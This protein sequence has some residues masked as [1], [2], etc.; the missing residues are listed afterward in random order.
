MLNKYVQTKYISKSRGKY[1]L[2]I[3]CR[4][5]FYHHNFLISV[6]CSKKGLQSDME[7]EFNETSLHRILI[8]V[9]D[10]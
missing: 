2:L 9:E 4:A 6:K 5:T 7:V 8:Y 3:L 1:C 10:V